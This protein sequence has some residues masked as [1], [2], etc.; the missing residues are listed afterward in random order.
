MRAPRGRQFCRACARAEDPR[1]IVE[2]LERVGPGPEAQPRGSQAGR[3]LMVAAVVGLLLY[4]IGSVFGAYE[5]ITSHSRPSDDTCRLRRSDGPTEV[6]LFDDVVPLLEAMAA[7]KAKNQ[8][9]LMGV[10]AQSTR[11][12]P[13]TRA[14]KMETVPT[15]LRIHV[16]DGPHAGLEGYVPPDQCR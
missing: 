12:A 9:R 13:G 15:W 5:A 8:L 6:A 1:A 10:E 3:T 7:S 4:G 14:R 2:D 16:L 11:V